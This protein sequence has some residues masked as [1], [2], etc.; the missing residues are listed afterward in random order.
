MKKIIILND[1]GLTENFLIYIDKIE[2]VSINEQS[3]EYEKYLKLSKVRV[4]NELFNTYDI[5]IQ[6]KYKI[7]I[8]YKA[9]NTVKNYFN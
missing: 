1:I 6:N 9:L 8:N 2:N 3:N 5:Y 7:D 4:T